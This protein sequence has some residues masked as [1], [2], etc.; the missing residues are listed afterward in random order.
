[1]RRSVILP[2]LPAICPGGRHVH[3]HHEEGNW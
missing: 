2:I 3:R 1:M